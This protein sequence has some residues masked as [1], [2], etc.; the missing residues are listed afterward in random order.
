[1]NS[2]LH[3]VIQGQASPWVPWGRLPSNRWLLLQ[4]LRGIANT[5]RKTTHHGVL[6]HHFGNNKVNFSLLHS[7]TS[8][9]IK[10]R[11]KINLSTSKFSYKPRA[12]F[13][14]SV[15]EPPP[16]IKVTGMLVISFRDRNCNFWSHLEC[17]ERKAKIFPI[18]I[19]VGVRWVHSRRA[20]HKDISKWKS[21]APPYFVEVQSP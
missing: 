19:S 21:Q 12:Y 4:T 11:K 20:V 6:S 13:F 7:S 2:Q 14:C 16:H 10:H 8:Q 1:M 15:P 3:Q 17:P 5:S 9:C 18:Q